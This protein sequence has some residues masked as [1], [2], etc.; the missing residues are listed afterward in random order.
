MNKRLATPVSGCRFHPLA[1][2]IAALLGLSLPPM[3][4]ATNRLV[5]SCLDDA[6]AGTLRNVIAAPSTVSGDEI[7]LTQLTNCPNSKITLVTGGSHIPISQNNLTIKGPPGAALTI[8]GSQLDS[9]PYNY[10]NLLYHTGSGTLSVSHLTLTGGHEKHQKI[11]AL[12]GCV[13]SKSNLSLAYVTISGCTNYSGYQTARGGA[14]YAGGNLT[15]NHSTIESSSASGAGA[16]GGAVF[17]KGTLMLTSSTLSGNSAVGKSAAYGGGAYAIGA[18]VA[19]SSHVDGNDATSA[20]GN[21]VGGGIFA[22]GTLTLTQS[23]LDANS[24]D[25]HS[26]ARGGGAY[27]LGNI[28]ATYSQILD[29]AVVSSEGLAR[30]GG[31]DAKGNL[32]LQ[33]AT[34]SG[35]SVSGSTFVYSSGGGARTAG[36]FQAT[37]STISD[38][39]AD[40]LGF[41]GGLTLTGM[42]NVIVASTISGNVSNT[43]FG[44]ID[45]FTAGAP[46]SSFV[47]RNSTLSGNHAAGNVGGLYTDSRTTAFY[48]STIAFNTAAADPGV[49][50]AA[51][52]AAVNVT[53]QSTLISNNTF[54]PS[55]SDLVTVPGGFSITFNGGNLATP[56]NNLVRVTSAPGLPSDTKGGYCPLLGPLRDNGGLTKTHALS[57]TS[58]A[59]AAGN[60]NSLFFF[61]QRGTAVVNGTLDY[62]RISGTPLLSDI[63]AYEVQDEIV[64]NA[65]FE[66]CPPMPF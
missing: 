40:G 50:I 1:A 55:E 58:P 56:A 14:V 32:S 23:S 44:G 54:G 24:L 35:N 46:S 41:G 52:S 3:A 63:G 60:N 62:V 26:D 42:L 65:G 45:V 9:S 39:V 43:A 5:T 47:L 25:A 31:F 48:N 59:I 21:T 2:G 34:L 19:Q 4:L 20:F 51:S 38:N 22:K 8:D 11:A 53:L 49:K 16:R 18:I 7:D 36:A 33:V 15:L 64:F 13:Y 10:S 28:T 6:G 17:A 57:S 12:G 29:N 27:A 37:Y 30:G 61:D 66:G